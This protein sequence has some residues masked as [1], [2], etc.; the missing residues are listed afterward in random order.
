MI[1]RRYLHRSGYHYRV[2]YPLFGK[3]DIVFPRQKVV[4]FVHGCFWHKHGCKNSVTP[5]TNT[6]F[7][8]NKLNQNIK[9][10]KAVKDK[11]KKE[12]WKVL[13]VWECEI[14][15]MK[16]LEKGILENLRRVKYES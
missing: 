7:W 16:I 10:D 3:P 13:I 14:E 6:Y 12:G 8:R 9:R 15:N 4:I 11:L 5:K 1:L 2:N